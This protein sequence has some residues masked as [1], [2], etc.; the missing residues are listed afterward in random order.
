M[1]ILS[2]LIVYVEP[3]RIKLG[4]A[5]SVLCVDVNLWLITRTIMTAWY[6][7]FGHLIRTAW[8]EG[9]LL[10]AHSF[11]TIIEYMHMHIYRAEA[12][13][14]CI[15]QTCHRY[16]S[17]IHPPRSLVLHLSF[18]GLPYMLNTHIYKGEF[19]MLYWKLLCKQ[20]VW[21]D[22]SFNLL[23]FRIVAATFDLYSGLHLMAS[24]LRRS[25]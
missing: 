15:C 12:L 9:E 23:P 4:K 5:P 2:V 20:L 22:S 6:N 17:S 3:R 7:Y 18:V 21:R 16:T 1:S 8:R 25:S 19:N 13:M 24:W 14:I 10:F 11:C